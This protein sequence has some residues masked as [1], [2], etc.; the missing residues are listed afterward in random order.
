MEMMGGD[1][2]SLMADS[3]LKLVGLVW[4][5]A[6]AWWTLTCCF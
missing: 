1:D 6:R 5:F 4:R 2:S 3:Q